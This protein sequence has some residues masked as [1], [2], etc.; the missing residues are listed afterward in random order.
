LAPTEDLTETR[1]SDAVPDIA[2]A[3]PI[4]GFI[5]LVVASGYSVVTLTAVLVWHWRAQGPGIRSL[6]PVSI[7]KPLCGPEPGLYE[8]LRS[9][10]LQ[11]FQEYQVIFGVLDRDDPALEVVERLKGEF[12]SLP[13][14]VVVTA[15][16]HGSNCKISNLINMMAKAR[17]DVLVMAD[18]DA[19]VGFDYLRIVTE[20][21]LDRS[22]GLVT[23]LYRAV[24]TRSIF[25]RLGAMYINEWY[26]P[27]VLLAWLFGYKNYVSGQT[28]CMRRDTVEAIGG[29]QAI[30][31]HLADDHELGD[32]VLSL[33]LRIV[34]SSYVPS[35][36]CHEPSFD[37]LTHHEVRWMRTLH[38]LRPISFPFIFF[39]FSVPLATLGFVLSIGSATSAMLTWTLLGLTLTIRLAIFLAHRIR[40]AR[41][42][43]R[44]LW[45]IPVRDFLLVWVWCSSMLTSCI[46]WRG[47]RFDVDAHGVMHR[48]S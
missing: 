36:E 11:A 38:V 17:Y 20:P 35:A 4:V 21:L 33:G 27:S 14:D 5:C 3:I 48:L 31:N 7:L 15:Q 18:S 43:L 42:K 37:S 28:L 34:L 45:L 12:P 26:M 23:C 8:N 6:P 1:T 32:R 9:F 29:L 2:A 44:D 16:Q 30:A 40:P 19:K 39:S 47:N 41:P 25:S 24:P 22:V 10:C 13:I 46:T